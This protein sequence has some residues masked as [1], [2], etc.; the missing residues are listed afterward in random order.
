[1]PDLCV[2]LRVFVCIEMLCERKARKVLLEAFDMLAEGLSQ[3][4]PG[5]FKV[6]ERARTA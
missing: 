1:M 6:E 3:C 5:F 4:E 2:V